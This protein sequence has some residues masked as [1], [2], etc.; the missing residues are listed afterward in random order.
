MFLIINSMKFKSIILLLAV[1]FSMMVSAQEIGDWW[2]DVSVFEVNKVSPRTN[3]IPYGDC[4]YS[5]LLI[6]DSSP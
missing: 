6:P 5:K 1:S 3:V 4:L 2:N